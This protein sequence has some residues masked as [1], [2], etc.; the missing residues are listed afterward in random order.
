MLENL[1][2]LVVKSTNESGGYGMLMGHQA[3]QEEREKFAEKIKADP[4]NFIAQPVVQLSQ[5]PSLVEDRFRGPAHRSAAV[6]SLRRKGDR[7][8]RRADARGAAQGKP[9]REQLPGRRQQ[10]HLGAGRSESTNGDATRKKSPT[11]PPSA[12][13]CPHADRSPM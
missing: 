4:R 8:A 11:M 3:T 12:V 9:G 5:H 10:R 13:E 7:H 1:H 6:H 2:K